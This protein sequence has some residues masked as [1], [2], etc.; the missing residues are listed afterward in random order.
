MAIAAIGAAVAIGSAVLGGIGAKKDRK[1][2]RKVYKEEVA[3]IRREGAEDLRRFD[4]QTREIQGQG[5]AS[6]F[7][8]GI[9]ESGSSKRYLDAL[10]SELATQRSYM[11]E[12]I[13]QRARLSRVGASQAAASSRW[14]SGSQTAQGILQGI[15]FYT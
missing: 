8:S 9:Q 15:S 12:N 10:G 1:Q 11:E 5:R 13:E 7:A 6:M 14:A 2:A 4:I 3:A